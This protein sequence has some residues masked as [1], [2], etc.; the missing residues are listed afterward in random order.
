M[1][2]FSVIVAVGLLA[3][4]AWA[5]GIFANSYNQA[6]SFTDANLDQT[7]MNMA[8]DG[9]NYWSSSGGGP[10]GN[11]L[12][13]YDAAGNLLNIYQPGIDFRSVFTRNS[14]GPLYARGFADNNV[15]VQS[16]P[17]AFGPFVTLAGSLDAQAAVG[18]DSTG[19]AA[20]AGGT[21]YRWDLS[22][23]L[24]S[25]TPL[26]GYGS[27]FGEGV[28]PQNRGV[29]ELGGNY[30]T[31][32]AGSLSAWDAGGNR[33][34]TTSLIGAGTSFDSHFSLSVANGMVWVVDGAG[35]STWRGYVV[36]EPASVLVAL[37]GVLALRR[38]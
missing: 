7:Q 4:C 13:Q 19:F 23:N 17:G 8:W 6:M 25:S 34:G 10:S 15:Q 38:R 14:S 30:L 1:S 36:P 3:T 21:L 18:A 37:L 11:R 12:A 29:G 16:S 31:Y 32:S 5:D 33:I 28:Y 9:V 22:G 20:A 2:K 24:L 26:I 27:L 35:G